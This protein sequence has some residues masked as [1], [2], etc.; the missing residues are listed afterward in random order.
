[1]TVT[2]KISRAGLKQG[3]REAYLAA[4]KKVQGEMPQEHDATVALV[5]ILKKVLLIR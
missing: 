1:M 3:T 4:E 2:Y 5:N